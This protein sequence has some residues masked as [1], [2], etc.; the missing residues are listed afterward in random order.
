MPTGHPTAGA[1]LTVGISVWR[2]AGRVGVGPTPAEK[3]IKTY[4]PYHNREC[5]HCHDGARRFEGGKTHLLEPGRLAKIK[6][7]EMS[8]MAKGCH[9][10]VHD[11]AN[12]EGMPLWSPKQK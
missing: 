12:L 6:S 7:N 10:F 3:D 4:E 11:V 1:M 9:E 2:G 8:C 5:L